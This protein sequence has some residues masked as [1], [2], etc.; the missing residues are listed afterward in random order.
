MREKDILVISKEVGKMVAISEI[1]GFVDA[2]IFDSIKK[3]CVECKNA[4]NINE[5]VDGCMEMANERGDKINK[6]KAEE[7][8]REFIIPERVI[9]NG[10]C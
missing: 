2:D 10:K 5:M 4:L 8:I 1:I 9:V 6:E 7:I 3:I